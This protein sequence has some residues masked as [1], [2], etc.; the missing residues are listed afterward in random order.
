MSNNNSNITSKKVKTISDKTYKNNIQ[1]KT[2]KMNKDNYK[3]MD[4]LT[5]G[6]INI[7]PA[8]FPLNFIDGSVP[9]YDDFL[10]GISK[11]SENRSSI[12]EASQN[13][14]E[15][16]SIINKSELNYNG[17]KRKESPNDLSVCEQL[18]KQKV[19]V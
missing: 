14:T 18:K 4:L 15:K 6:H 2:N 5:D 7:V 9:K 11:S 19:M 8:Y 13:D 12:L 10:M 1:L 17:I 16:R 3:L